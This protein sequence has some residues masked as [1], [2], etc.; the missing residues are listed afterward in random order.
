MNDYSNRQ[1]IGNHASGGGAKIVNSPI[2]LTLNFNI[3]I[4]GRPD[5]EQESSLVQSIVAAVRQALIGERTAIAFNAQTVLEP[6]VPR[7]DVW[8]IQGR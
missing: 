3:R 4:T 8:D 5:P 1:G 6:S 7:R 2:N